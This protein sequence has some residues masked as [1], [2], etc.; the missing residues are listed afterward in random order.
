MNKPFHVNALPFTALVALAILFM[1]AAQAVFETRLL[2]PL[3]DDVAQLTDAI[4]QQRTRSAAHLQQRPTAVVQLEAIAS[5][6]PKQDATQTRIEQ[7]HQIATRH[8]VVVRKVSYK[9]ADKDHEEVSDKAQSSTG[10]AGR[11]GIQADIAGAYPDL[12]Q[13]LRAILAQD[14]ALAI[15]SLEFSRPPDSKGVRAQVRMTLYFQRVP[16]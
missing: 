10:H 4:G 7:L 9:R 2:A 6:L 11:H 3:A 14:E 15:E 8:A 16:S 5:R 12:R 1:L 13:F